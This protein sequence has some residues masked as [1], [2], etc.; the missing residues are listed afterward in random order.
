MD[1]VTTGVQ[2][3]MPKFSP[4]G[5]DG[6]AGSVFQWHYRALRTIPM[7]HSGRLRRSRTAPRP[8]GLR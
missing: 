2:P 3:P 6:A 7:P 1:N 8:H 5:I 4:F